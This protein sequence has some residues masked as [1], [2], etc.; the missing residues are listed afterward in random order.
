MHQIHISVLSELNFLSSENSDWGCTTE[1][2]DHSSGD[3]ALW[4]DWE[5]S[6]RPPMEVSE[7]VQGQ[8]AE[9]GQ[10]ERQTRLRAN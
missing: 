7:A 1:R 3:P 5:S 8:K 6:L 10:E 4:R 9:A 2:P